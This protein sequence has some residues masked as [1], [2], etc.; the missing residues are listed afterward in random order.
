MA[1]VHFRELE[2]T[3]AV[4]RAELKRAVRTGEEFE[5]TVTGQITRRTLPFL[6]MIEDITG[7]PIESTAR[8][9]RE[10][11]A[12]SLARCQWQRG[13]RTG[14]D[15]RR[16]EATIEFLVAGNQIDRV[17]VL[18]ISLQTDLM[19][20]GFSRDCRMSQGK[21][22]QIGLTTLMLAGKYAPARVDYWY[23]SPWW[24]TT[25]TMND[26]VLRLQDMKGC[27]NV[28]FTWWIL[29]AGL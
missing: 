11:S 14:S 2:I 10:R 12:Q 17:F 3:D 18:E 5:L 24:P 6:D 1:Y 16:P 26:V 25:D 27:D 20:L 21:A 19:K 29:D 22:S 23:L 8:K 28:F 15:S 7:T 13:H 4:V 9:S